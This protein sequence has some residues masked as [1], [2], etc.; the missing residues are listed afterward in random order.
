MSEEIE[1]A[2]KRQNAD[3]KTALIAQI[4]EWH[5]ETISSLRHSLESLKNGA[6]AAREC[7]LRLAVLRD[8]A[9][10]GEWEKLFRTAQGKNNIDFVFEFD[11][12]TARS[13]IKIARSHPE[14]FESYEEAVPFLRDAGRLTKLLPEAD[15]HGDQQR[16]ELTFATVILD[17]TGKIN[18]TL[19]KF[20]CDRA[21]AQMSPHGR[22]Q[23]LAQLK[24]AKERIDELWGMLQ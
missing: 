3:A 1:L 21:I 24:P 19:A 8:H 10:H 13:Y 7:G 11:S 22:E 2:A 20:P 4:N 17:I 14:A 16:H 5:S 18:S 23:A 15:G 6:N 12:Q 9:R